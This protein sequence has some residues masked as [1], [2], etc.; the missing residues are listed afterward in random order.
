MGKRKPPVSGQY[1]NTHQPLYYQNCPAGFIHTALLPARKD[2]GTA[3][4]TNIY[5]DSLRLTCVSSVSTAVVAHKLTHTFTDSADLG[6][7][8]NQ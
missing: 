7:M 1:K 8:Y 4:Y 6:L 3:L 5:P 2:G